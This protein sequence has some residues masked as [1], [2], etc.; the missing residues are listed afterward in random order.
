MTRRNHSL[1]LMQATQE[2]PTLARL[3]ALSTDSAARLKAI[4]PLIPVALQ[5]SIKAGPIDGPVWCVIVDNNAAAAKVRQLLPSFE[6]LLR[7]KGWEINS[8][9][10]KVQ[11]SGS[12]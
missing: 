4:Q 9:R 1:T 8:I 11:I 5:T 12:R 2:S 7:V 3:T 10:L 6:S